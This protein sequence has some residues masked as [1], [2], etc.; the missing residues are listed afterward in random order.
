MSSNNQASTTTTKTQAVVLHRLALEN[1][2]HQWNEQQANGYQP[3]GLGS[4][5]GT[6]HQIG[7]PAVDNS[8]SANQISQPESTD[9]RQNL[10]FSIDL[11][12]SINRS[13]ASNNNNDIDGNDNREQQN[14]LHRNEPDL[15][16]YHQFQNN[17]TSD[18]NQRAFQNNAMSSASTIQQWAVANRSALIGAGG[19]NN[20]YGCLLIETILK[21]YQKLHDQQ[22]LYVG[23]SQHT[24]D[25]LINCSNLIGGHEASAAADIGQDLNRKDYHSTNGLASS[26]RIICVDE[27]VDEDSDSISEENLEEFAT[28]LSSNDN[29]KSANRADDISTGSRQRITSNYLTSQPFPSDE[30]KQ[31]RLHQ[32]KQQLNDSQASKQLAFDQSINIKSSKM[33]SP[34]NKT[35]DGF[36]GF[37]EKASLL[38]ETNMMNMNETFQRDG[39]DDSNGAGTG[40]VGKNRRCRTNFSVEQIRE[41]E[42]LF[43]ETHYPDAFM[44][45]DI[46]SRLK[47]SENRV[48]VWFQNRRAKCRKE[49]ARSSKPYAGSISCNPISSGCIG[50]KNN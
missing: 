39:L 5:S 4:I 44:R 30:I 2:L 8:L 28:N 23:N 15:H 10:N 21:Q 37:D 25:Q 36:H 12:A 26:N 13:A 31:K 18:N 1:L 47:L 35:I 6:H 24:P 45:E 46:S 40:S 32:A 22:L 19:S 27:D 48:Q 50:N 9:F 38:G 29:I 20:N 43:D 7:S 41:L 42:K 33:V 49:E 34:I 16:R 3:F 14:F 11:M 17:T